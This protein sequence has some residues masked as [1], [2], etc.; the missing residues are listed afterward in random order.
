MPTTIED[1]DEIRELIARYV[2]AFDRGDVPAWV[3]CYREDGELVGAGRPL[4][5]R[6][7]LGEF[8]A[9]HPPSGLHRFTSDFVI[10]VDGDNARCQSSV[11]ILSGGAIVSSGR[12]VD[13]LERVDGRW[14]IA[15]RDYT[16]DTAS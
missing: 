10:D 5:G 9:A 12:V 8:L 2:A 7:A 4:Q 13:Q 3:A 1:K 16:P 14:Q 15:R 6:Q 11:A